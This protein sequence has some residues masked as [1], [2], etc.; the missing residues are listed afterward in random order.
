MKVL[1]SADRRQGGIVS[2]RWLRV[3]CAVVLGFACVPRETWAARDVCDMLRDKGLL[4][5]VEYNECKAAQEK[6]D[7]KSEEK[8]RE[9]LGLR[10]PKWLDMI[11]PFGDVRVR[12]EGFY[13]NDLNARSR[14]RF[15]ARIGLNVV[16]SDEVS[17][18]IRLATGNP[19]DPISTN[20]SFEKV[21]TR[22]PVQLDQAY[23]TI[24][25]G[26][27]F[28]L[29][30]GWG[31]IT[32]GKFNVNSFR[33]SELVF[34]DD[35]VPE[36]ATETLNLVELKEGFWR[37]LRLN[38]FQW[39]VDE[40]SAD[41][42]PW[43]FGGQVVT[44]T[45]FGSVANLS[46]ALADFHYE[47]LNAVAAKYLSPTKT[48]PK[49]PT[50]TVAN[51]SFDSQLANS[52]RLV[53]DS[54]GNIVAFQERFNIINTTSELNFANPFKIGI[55]AGL[56]ADLAVNTQANNDNVGF[57]VGAGIGKPGKDWYHN[58]LK[59]VRDWAAS[60]TFARVEQDAVF[61]V[62]S[63]SDL[64]YVN[65]GATQKGSSNV[66]AHILRLDYMLLPN[67]QLTAKCH[68][69]NA[70]DSSAST[71]ALKGNPTL[72]RPQFDVAFKF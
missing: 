49:D 45:A 58:S 31:S 48:N 60:Y 21:F 64:D 2:A 43:M 15:R 30:P 71:V 32:G 46:V 27:T 50:M 35:L 28:G 53:K 69:I 6:K 20:Q 9:V 42:D 12:Y 13:G 23:I 62:F 65:A 56:F 54:L 67:L 5:D 52:N 41:E 29:T 22:K 36:G 59:N 51:P 44:D 11:T 24:K 34:D 70:L 14:M 4:N 39:V 68:V 8:T 16:P 38:A 17:S 25:P 40:L 63:Y 66:I 10:L 1:S 37:G 33:L 47:G 61:A 57:H 3:I 7:V 72:F 18:T 55:P 26:S 19:D